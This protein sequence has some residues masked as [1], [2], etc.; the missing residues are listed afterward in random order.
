MEQQETATPEIAAPEGQRDPAD[1]GDVAIL[2]DWEN[3]KWGLS[4]THGLVPNI[5]SLLDAAHDY[6]RLV[7][8]R[9][10]GD[11]TDPLLA[12]DAPN[13]YRS[14][15]EPI[16]AQGR[17]KDGKP[18]KNSADVRLT[19]DAVSMCSQLSHVKTYILVTGD[20]DLIHPLNYIRL[21]GRRVVIF[22]VEE[23]VSDLLST[24]ADD[25]LL[26][27]EHIDPNAVRA[28][29]SSR[30]VPGSAHSRRALPEAVFQWIPEIVAEQP[31]R[32]PFT[33]LGDV[34][35][36]EY[37]FNARDYGLLLKQ[38]MLIAQE[39]GIIEVVTEAGRD[40]AVIPGELVP[41]GTEDE[42]VEQL[43]PVA[44]SS[45]SLANLSIEDQHKLLL[46]L[47]KLESKSPYVTMGY[48]IANIVRH[49]V[50]PSLSE[51]QVRGLVGSA[52]RSG[53]IKLDEATRYINLA[54]ED[55]AVRAALDRRISGIVTE[56]NDAGSVDITGPD[57]SVYYAIR[58]EFR[59]PTVFQEAQLGA[60]VDFAIKRYPSD[61]EF[62]LARDVQLLETNR[63][64]I[65]ELPQ[66]PLP[67]VSPDTTVEE[68]VAL[69]AARMRGVVTLRDRY[70][71]A[72]SIL[73]D[74]TSYIFSADDLAPGTEFSNVLRNSAVSFAPVEPGRATLVAVI[75][76]AEGLAP[77]ESPYT[78]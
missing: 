25:V 17:R 67:L 42:A 70:K 1:R 2:I 24:A 54:L 46:Y 7:V 31:A 13:L 68:T 63:A 49:S 18:L 56:R 61:K 4:N 44:P 50:L 3:L 34:L 9:A 26:Y 19:V 53:V 32:Y 59:D 23:T 76:D 55:S 29:P 62:G 52:I 73:C 20:G 37:G 35:K 75:L 16:Y 15:I 71:K 21:C 58:G 47:Q 33:K 66:E 40:Y 38:V 65:T 27:R 45:M 51:E 72:G 77:S 39:K 11:W 10:Y 78:A 8:A 48:A 22:A 69:R 30:V 6:G 14:G 5:T 43:E 74:G 64:P 28:V 36:R 41:S 60:R 57:G 12:V